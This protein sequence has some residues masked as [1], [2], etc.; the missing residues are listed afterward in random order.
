MHKKKQPK[1]IRSFRP[2]E[3]RL[4]KKFRELATLTQAL[5]GG[6]KRLLVWHILAIRTHTSTIQNLLN[7]K[8][9]CGVEYF[10]VFLNIHD[11]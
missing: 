2:M 4:R 6:D 9:F 7:C 8:R 1:T 11:F 3:Y 10:T 5:S